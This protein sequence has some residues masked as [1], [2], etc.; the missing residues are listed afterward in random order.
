MIGNLGYGLGFGRNF[1]FNR[2]LNFGYFF[3]SGNAVHREAFTHTHTLKK[4]ILKGVKKPNHLLPN[5]LKFL[6]F[7]KKY[8]AFCMRTTQIKSRQQAEL[9]FSEC[10]FC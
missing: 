8:S 7:D 5:G 2:N 4:W 6:E 1:T 9:S 3:D 10:N